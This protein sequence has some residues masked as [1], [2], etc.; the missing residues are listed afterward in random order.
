MKGLSVNESKVLI[1][2]QEVE[3]QQRPLIELVI[4]NFSERGLDNEQISQVLYELK[5]D[6]KINIKS[7]ISENFPFD[8][9][10]V[11]HYEYLH[12]LKMEKMKAWK[13]YDKNNEN[14]Y[15]GFV[16]AENEVEAAEKVKKQH[17]HFSDKDLE[18][19]WKGNKGIWKSKSFGLELIKKTVE[20][21]EK[22]RNV[23]K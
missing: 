3:Y 5:L 13:I 6:K 22:Y 23:I 19:I 1:E 2:L 14:M 17:P 4:K 21:V 8:K 15:V 20:E 10:I 12:S 7:V 9:I 11:A 18:V 16:I